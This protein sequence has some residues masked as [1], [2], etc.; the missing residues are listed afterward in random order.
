M[1]RLFVLAMFIMPVDMAYCQ[2]S[3]FEQ[4]TRQLDASSQPLV[5]LV[6][7][8]G[9]LDNRNYRDGVIEIADYKRR[10]D[11]DSLSVRYRCKIRYR[12]SSALRYGKKSFAVKLT[13][14]NGGD[15]DACILGIREE[16]R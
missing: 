2:T 15:L 1:L 16:N 12:G 3:L 8:T 6:V 13:D 9:R 4:M 10:T 5:N 7:D 14:E 11:P